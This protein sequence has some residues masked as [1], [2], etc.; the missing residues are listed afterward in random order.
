LVGIPVIASGG[1]GTLDQI[2]EA[3]APQGGNADA[4]LV[5]S[6]LHFGQT[7]ITEIKRHA[8]MKG[9]CIRW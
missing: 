7:T 1:A 3:I 4:A 2:A 6:M 5:A 9:A 8:E